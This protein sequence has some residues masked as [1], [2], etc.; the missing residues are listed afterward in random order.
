MNSLDGY[1]GK[2]RSALKRKDIS[3][4]LWTQERKRINSS[5]TK[6]KATKLLDGDNQ[7]DEAE[8]LEVHLKDLASHFEPIIGKD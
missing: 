2:M 6:E 7:Q 5:I 3:S 4:K 8:V 1:V